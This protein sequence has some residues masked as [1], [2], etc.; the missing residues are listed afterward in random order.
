LVIRP[1]RADLYARE[2]QK[3]ISWPTGVF[4]NKPFRTTKERQEVGVEIIAR[5]LP[6]GIK[7]TERIRQRRGLTIS[8]L[9]HEG[10]T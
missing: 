6:P 1:C 10:T 2:Y 3:A 9:K 5:R 8:S 7:T 4:E